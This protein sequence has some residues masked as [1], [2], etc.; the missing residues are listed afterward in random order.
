MESIKTATRAAFLEQVLPKTDEERSISGWFVTRPLETSFYDKPTHYVGVSRDEF[1]GKAWAIPVDVLG[2]QTG[3]SIEVYGCGTHE[4]V[5]AALG[6]A[7]T[8]PLPAPAKPKRTPARTHLNVADIDRETG[9]PVGRKPACGQLNGTRTDRAQ[10]HYTHDTAK[11]T[12]QRCI[13]TKL[14]AKA[15][16]DEFQA[17][18]R[19]AWFDAL[20]NNKELLKRLSKE[21][22]V[23]I[24]DTGLVEFYMPDEEQA[25]EYSAVVK[26]QDITEGASATGTFGIRADGSG[27]DV[28]DFSVEGGAQ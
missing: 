15:M 2:K 11:V 13:T 10:T 4:A 28:L 14:F 8:A 25:Q 3:A 17:I 23:V 6:Y 5:L 22:A 7:I 12:C 20:E 1:T 21:R 16:A 9:K 19:K 18:D 26:T 24:P 27:I